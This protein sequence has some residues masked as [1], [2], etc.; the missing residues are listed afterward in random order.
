MG[1]DGIGHRPLWA[2]GHLDSVE[3]SRVVALSARHP[4][5]P[6]WPWAAPDSLN[7]RE[8]VTGKGATGKREA[9]KEGKETNNLMVWGRRA[10]EA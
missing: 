5:T 3:C 8:G 9:A 2:G 4:D 10:G 1:D 6:D 7:Q